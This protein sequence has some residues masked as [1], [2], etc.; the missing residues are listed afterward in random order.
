MWIA[1]AAVTRQRGA[2]WRWGVCQ[3]ASSSNRP[4]PD[5]SLFVD[6]SE[7]LYS[8]DLQFFYHESFSNFSSNAS[9]ITLTRFSPMI[10]NEYFS[11]TCTTTPCLR[12]SWPPVTWKGSGTHMPPLVLVTRTPARGSPRLHE[13]WL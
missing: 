4:L 2:R 8:I 10:H 6:Q 3:G 11:L 1:N 9:Q 7:M 5:D 13:F 12:P